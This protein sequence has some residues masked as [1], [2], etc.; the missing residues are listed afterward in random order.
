[1]IKSMSLSEILTE[2]S[3]K[4]G[5]PFI[6]ATWDELVKIA[7]VKGELGKKKFPFFALEPNIKIKEGESYYWNEL[8]FVLYF[9]AE[10]KSND[11]S[12]KKQEIFVN[13]VYPIIDKFF[14]C[15]QKSNY[16]ETIKDDGLIKYTK[17]NI[18]NPSTTANDLSDHFVCS[19]LDFKNVKLKKDLPGHDYKL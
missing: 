11:S 18:Y 12:A 6:F 17:E 19:K 4:M 10:C 1:M 2:Y 9:M 14:K 5:V 3:N 7:L 8:D 16:F 15:I 13:S